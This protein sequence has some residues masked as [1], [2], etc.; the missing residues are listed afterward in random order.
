MSVGVVPLHAMLD[1]KLNLADLGSHLYIYLSKMFHFINFEY[2]L[3]ENHISS[4]VF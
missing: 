4:Y 3:V 1:M 2:A